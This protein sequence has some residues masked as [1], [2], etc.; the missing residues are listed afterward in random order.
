VRAHLQDASRR[1]QTIH[2][3]KKLP[4]NH[5]KDGAP[6]RLLDILQPNVGH[7]HSGLCQG[8]HSH[9]QWTFEHP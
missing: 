8:G 7:A 9:S 1:Q 3:T 2:R 6:L 5:S 4:E